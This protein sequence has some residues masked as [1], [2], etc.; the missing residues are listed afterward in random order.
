MK[1]KKSEWP[2]AFE[3]SGANYVFDS[4]SGL[5]YEAESDF[6]YDPKNK[7]YYS[8]EKK[9]YY[10]HNPENYESSDE[11]SV[12]EEVKPEDGAMGGPGAVVGGGSD[13]AE[14]KDVSQDLLVQALQGG[15]GMSGNNKQ[16]KTKINICIKKKFSGGTNANAKKKVQQSNEVSVSASKASQEKE[17]VSLAEK[18][19]GANIEKWIQRAGEAKVDD[20]CTAIDS[21]CAASTGKVKMTKAGKP[22]CFI[23]KRKF[24]N[25]EK[26]KQH[27]QLSALHK[28]NLAKKKKLEELS[29]SKAPEYRDRAKE[30][31]FMYEAD[32]NVAAPAIDPSIV[33][34][35][36]SLDRARVVTTTEKVAP[37]Q[38]LG[39]SN[40][41][42]QLLQKL[43]WK[44]GGSL[45]R[46]GEEKDLE[47]RAGSA[48]MKDKLKQDWERIEQLSGK[49]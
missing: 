27:E 20:I 29:N 34:M 16:E 46:R 21:S 44:S 23:C 47:F 13:A 38:S 43:G 10:R 26:L 40:V 14:G 17:K 48:D 25:L 24:L 1:K 2:S 37:D 11:S 12:W 45:G 9:L 41:G 39:E 3:E 33:E 28:E 30:R 5:F 8:N 7:M 15:T 18:A 49:N 19:R 35:G 32:S 22:I 42:N 6:F 36:P 31:R 4:R